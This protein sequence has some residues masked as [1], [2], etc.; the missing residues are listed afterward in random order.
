MAF[1]ENL[2]FTML[3]QLQEFG[4]DWETRLQNS[5]SCI[6]FYDLKIRKFEFVH[7]NLTEDYHKNGSKY[8]A[9][10]KSMSLL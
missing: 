6:K 2:N 1:L 10:S 9:S 5:V 7:A 3:Q 8:F 4:L